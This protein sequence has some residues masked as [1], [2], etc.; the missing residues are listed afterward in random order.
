MCETCKYEEI[1][2]R[3]QPETS[4]TRKQMRKDLATNL[5]KI[6]QEY[7]E[8]YKN[9]KVPATGTDTALF[10]NIHRFLIES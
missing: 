3:S 4:M 1:Y 6:E 2:K 5:G 10:L 7:D 8:E 9:F